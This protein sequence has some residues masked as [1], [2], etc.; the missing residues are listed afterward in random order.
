MLEGTWLLGFFP[1]EQWPDLEQKV[2]FLP[3]F[4]VPDKDNQTA[5][6]MGG[7]ELSIP[8]TSKY[9]ELAW[10]LITIILEPKIF[11]P[12]DQK[13]GYLPTQ[14]PIGEGPYSAELQKSIPYYDELIS[15]IP[16]GRTRPSI[17]E[18]P[19]I[20][21]HIRQ[22]IDEVYYSLKEPKEALDDAVQKSAKA[23]GW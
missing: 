3:M 23:L 6:L 19:E 16:I 11:A 20:A 8:K 5:S 14:I 10:E 15:M 17:P 4:P 18:Y 21:D 22:A 9:K 13:Y 7:W 1:A 12:L 2:G